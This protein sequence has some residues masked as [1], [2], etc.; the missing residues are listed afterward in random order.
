LSIPQNEFGVD[1]EDRILKIQTIYTDI[2]S[3]LVAAIPIASD[4]S[5]EVKSE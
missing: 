1:I 4:D 2:L 3:Q 5:S